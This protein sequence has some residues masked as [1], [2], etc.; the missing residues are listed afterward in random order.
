[1]PRTFIERV[2]AEM[3]VELPPHG[4]YGVGMAFLPQDDALR[5]Q[6]KACMDDVRPCRAL[7]RVPAGV[8]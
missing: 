3:G 5:A 4:Q 8:L 1:M 2:T 6:V 7:C